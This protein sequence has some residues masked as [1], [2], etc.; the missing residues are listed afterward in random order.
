MSKDA[1]VKVAFPGAGVEGDVADHF[2]TLLGA[3]DVQLGVEFEERKS[4]VLV[5]ILPLGLPSSTSA[6]SSTR[7]F[8]ISDPGGAILNGKALMVPRYTSIAVQWPALTMT[9]GGTI[10]TDLTHCCPR[11][12]QANFYPVKSN[13]PPSHNA[14]ARVIQTHA[15]CGCAQS[16]FG[17]QTKGLTALLRS[18]GHIHT[19]VTCRVRQS[20]MAVSISS[21]HID[22]PSAR[23]PSKPNIS[24]SGRDSP[25]ALPNG[26]QY[27]SIALR[28]WRNFVLS[29]GL[30]KISP[31]IMLVSI[32]TGDDILSKCCSR[33]YSSQRS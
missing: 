18:R 16:R 8:G 25:I 32:Q 20:L 23:F 31:I 22:T 17:I 3:W 2:C 5:G 28:K 33:A 14:T 27:P 9:R 21:L 19:A 13:T 10:Q 6:F 4:E 24:V 26:T 29:R 15:V 30:V 1:A 12:L 11:E 7:K